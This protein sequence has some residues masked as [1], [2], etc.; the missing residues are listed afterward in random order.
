MATL[1]P[2]N[3]FLVHLPSTSMSI[4]HTI[5]L[6]QSKQAARAQRKGGRV[7]EQEERESERLFVV[8]CFR[9][10]DY[11]FVTILYCAILPNGFPVSFL[12]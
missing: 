6:H 4:V 8:G 7:E 11:Q 3:Q 5:L 10:V 2:K 12:K 1:S 9:L